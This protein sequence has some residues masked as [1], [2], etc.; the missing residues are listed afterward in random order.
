MLTYAGGQSELLDRIIQGASHV[1]EAVE[2]I[3]FELYA[4]DVGELVRLHASWE[5]PENS[6]KTL[7]LM[8]R[9]MREASIL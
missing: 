8:R 1:Q 2:L 5:D 3:A 4:H 9:L 6:K 7:Q